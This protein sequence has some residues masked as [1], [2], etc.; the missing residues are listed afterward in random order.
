MLL[1][2]GAE[3]LFLK[4]EA[5]ALLAVEEELTLEWDVDC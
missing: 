1:F 3:E 5:A 2:A 4:L